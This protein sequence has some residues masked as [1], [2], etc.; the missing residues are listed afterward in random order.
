MEKTEINF[1]TEGNDSS[2]GK[3]KRNRTDERFD[4]DRSHLDVLL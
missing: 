4:L 1:S 2:L 3:Q